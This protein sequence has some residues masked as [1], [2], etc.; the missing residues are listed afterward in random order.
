MLAFKGLGA[1]SA[2]VN[3]TTTALRLHRELSG[4]KFSA[5]HSRE[6]DVLER[7]VGW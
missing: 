2:E 5:A 6:L 7:W 1:M 3:H 4:Q